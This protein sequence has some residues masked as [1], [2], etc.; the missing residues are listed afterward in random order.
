[1]PNVAGWINALRIQYVSSGRS[2]SRESLRFDS[3]QSIRRRHAN[4]SLSIPR[5]DPSLPLD[6]AGRLARDVV[7]D[8]VDALDLVDD[9]GGDMGEVSGAPVRRTAAKNAPSGPSWVLAV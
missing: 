2:Q 8:A 1:V 6:R 4:L 9:A 5:Y 7:D 3:V